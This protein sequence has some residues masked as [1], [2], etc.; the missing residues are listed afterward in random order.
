[1]LNIDS[2]RKKKRGPSVTR[3]GKPGKVE[4][5]DGDIQLHINIQTNRVAEPAYTPRDAPRPKSAYAFHLR[6]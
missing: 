6:T 1:M 4:H 2:D 5:D 3:A